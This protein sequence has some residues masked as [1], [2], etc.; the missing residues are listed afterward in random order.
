MRYVSVAFRFNKG[1]TGGPGG[2]NYMV[3]QCARSRG[4][5]SLRCYFRPELPKIINKVLNY[6]NRHA[7]RF[8]GIPI[9]EYLFNFVFILTIVALKRKASYIIHDPVSSCIASLLRIRFSQVYHHQGSLYD[10]HLSFGG[11]PSLRLRKLYTWLEKSGF[12]RAR[13][14]CFPSKGAVE[15]YFTTSSLNRS[16][17]GHKIRVIHNTINEAV[18]LS[19]EEYVYKKHE[20]DSGQIL[21]LTVSSLSIAK[22]IDRCPL[23]FYYLKQRKFRFKWILIGNG[24][25]KNEIYKQVERY[26]LEDCFIYIREFMPNTE[27][28]RLMSIARFYVMFHRHSI[29]DM[30]ILEAMSVGCIPVLSRVEGNLEFNVKNNVIFFDGDYQDCVDRILETNFERLASLNSKVYRTYFNNEV[31]FN[32]YMRLF[33]DTARGGVFQR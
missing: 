5:K 24:I 19:P 2:V 32:N 22:G 23:L 27:V 14:I 31:F 25:L 12:N 15:A 6:A 28:R 29:C 26:S 9:A 8:T 18:E 30:A 11:A 13:Y 17:Y 20:L 21:F 1:A 4:A 33:E 7:L 16:D 10:E 3:G